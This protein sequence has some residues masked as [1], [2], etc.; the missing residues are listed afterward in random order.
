MLYK[1]NTECR[2]YSLSFSNVSIKSTGNAMNLKIYTIIINFPGISGSF[3][4]KCL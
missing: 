4:I 2:Q 1:P 3:R